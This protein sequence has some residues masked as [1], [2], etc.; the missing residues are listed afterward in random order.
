MTLFAN[1]DETVAT[2]AGLFPP[3]WQQGL[4]G[5]TVY[6]VLALAFL[7]VGY[8]VIDWITPGKL[9]HQL[10]GSTWDKNTKEWVRHTPDGQP[11]RALAAVVGAMFLGLCIIIAAAIH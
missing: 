9:C 4:L 2:A 8:I 11:N 3:N 7:L 5:S 1:A 6:F 10:L